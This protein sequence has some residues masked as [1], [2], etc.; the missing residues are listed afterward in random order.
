[1]CIASIAMIA[2]DIYGYSPVPRICGYLAAENDVHHGQ[3]RLLGYGLPPPGMP[4][5]VRM[6]KARYGIQYR[7]VAGCVVSRS[8]MDFVA[9]YNNVSATAI[10]RKFGRDVV[11]ET[12]NEAFAAVK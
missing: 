7:A 10:G 1:M 12:E 4:R 9:A 8:Q 6:L 5:Y 3:Y 2:W 11:R